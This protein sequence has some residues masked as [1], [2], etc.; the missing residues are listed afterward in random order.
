VTRI[1]ER[2]RAVEAYYADVWNRHDK[3]RIPDL[4][5]PDVEFRGSL[6]QTRRGHAGFA[7]YVDFVHA[8][9]GDYRCDILDIVAD[10]GRVFARMRF[11]GVHRGELFGF[12]PTGKRVEWAGAALFTFD[13]DLISSIWVLGDVHSLMGLLREQSPG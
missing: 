6:G 3:T 2:R 8:A 10:E 13:G 1:D 9:L 7:H 11:S 4:L 5:H 12:A